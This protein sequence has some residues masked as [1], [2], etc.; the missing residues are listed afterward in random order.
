[1]WVQLYF[2]T[3]FSPPKVNMTGLDLGNCFSADKNPISPQWT[4]GLSALFQGDGGEQ[5]N[6][7]VF[8]P[9]I[10]GATRHLETLDPELTDAAFLCLAEPGEACELSRPTATP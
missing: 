7:Y 8:I 6:R 5:F 10:P 9:A 2:P 4:V 3:G 1:M